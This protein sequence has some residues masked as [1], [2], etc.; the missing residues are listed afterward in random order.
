M[1]QQGNSQG[2]DSGAPYSRPQG[3]MGGRGRQY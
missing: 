3:G 2:R 1:R